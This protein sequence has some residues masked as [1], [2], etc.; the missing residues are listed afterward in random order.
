[1]LVGFIGA[2]AVVETA[3]LPAIARLALPDLQCFGYDPHSERVLENITLCNSLPELLAMPLDIVIITTPSLLHLPVLEAVLQSPTAQIVI[4]KP[5]VASLEQISTLQTLL[6]NPAHS[7]RVLAIDHWMVRTDAIQF[8]SHLDKIERIEGFLLEPSGF[9]DAGEPVALNFATGH[10]DTRQ[11]RHP[12]GVIVDIGTHVLAMMRETL[13]QLGGH[14]E[15]ALELVCAHDRLGNEIQSGDFTTAEGDAVLKGTLSGI[16]IMLTLN[17]YAGPA[18]GQKGMK[19][20]LHDG[21]VINVDRR[22]TDEVVEV[23]NTNSSRQHKMS[24]PLYDR[25]LK[26]VVLGESRIF[27]RNPPEIP[28][29]TQ[30]RITEVEALLALQQKLRGKH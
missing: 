16:P 3:W 22:G 12:D 11:L 23:L 19:V 28:A 7:S 24:G 21:R 13:H 4:E 30:R 17:K 1:M 9:N 26:E 2:G 8:I 5:V 20:F 25:C 10:A 6:G 27:K 14:D 29:L 15:L 18:G